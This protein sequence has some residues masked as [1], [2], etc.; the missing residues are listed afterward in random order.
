[1]RRR[2]VVAT[3]RTASTVRPSP[4][5]RQP[6][7]HADVGVVAAGS[8]R[9]FPDAVAVPAR[10][11]IRVPAEERHDGVHRGSCWI[12]SQWGVVRAVRAVEHAAWRGDR[13]SDRLRGGRKTLRDRAWSVQCARQ[14]PTVGTRIP[15]AW[16]GCTGSFD[17]SCST[18]RSSERWMPGSLPV[19]S[20]CVRGGSCALT[21]RLAL[22]R[23]G[24]KAAN[25]LINRQSGVRHAS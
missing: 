19:V 12:V 14:V 16:N 21:T 2:S 22:D 15:K 7:A 4:V 1:M 5:P 13:P 3:G 20:A 10:L 11:P 24:D 6:H 23:P 25:S 18:T 9:L 8:R 17:S